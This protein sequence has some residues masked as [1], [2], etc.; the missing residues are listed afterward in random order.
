MQGPSSECGV[1]PGTAAG[2][3]RL[4]GRAGLF[5]S[6]L[7]RGDLRVPEVLQ[8]ALHSVRTHFGM[9]VACIA[10]IRDGE[11]IVRH[12]DCVPGAM[13]FE[14]GDRRPLADTLCKAM[15]DDRI[16]AAIQDTAL[17][18]HASRLPET[19]DLRIGCYLGVPIRFADGELWG[20]FSCFSA[21]P[22][23]TLNH[24]DAET[25]R[26]FAEFV[27]ATL[28]SQRGEM[29]SRQQ[30]YARVRKMLDDR[31]Y[32]VAFQPIVSVRHLRPVGYEA[33]TRFHGDA[34]VSTLQWFEDAAAVGLLR[35]LEE[36]VLQ[37][38][39]RSVPVLPRGAY[40]SVNVSPSTVLDGRLEALLERMP[41]RRLVLEITEHA[42]ISD[43]EALAERLRPLRDAGL[44]VAVDD[45]G[46]G[47]A[48]FRHI[49]KMHPD[50]IKLDISLIRKI[51]SD[52]SARALA[53]ALIRFA[54]ET[55]STVVAEG[56]E[57]ESV[58]QVLR[59]LHV[60]KAQGY[61]FGKA[62]PLPTRHD[63]RVARPLA[64]IA[65]KQAG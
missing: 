62:G 50:D 61:L 54:R 63:L 20:T 4:F 19:R 18:P 8:H 59:T 31:A 44:R 10:E 29:A 48:S 7:E 43:Y 21:R 60:H 12:L 35:E 45:A 25:L 52:T 15:L 1:E 32:G 27:A 65:G 5:A 2:S 26:V 33:L 6:S 56:V 49:L 39:L 47:F 17:D 16:A 22:D 46:A 42:S 37:E 55:G 64:C 58:L 13:R 3:G 36:A 40:L 24:R 14:E 9:D 53:A 51:D 11:R 57:S 23:R 34:T 28:E 38:A 30:V 41:L